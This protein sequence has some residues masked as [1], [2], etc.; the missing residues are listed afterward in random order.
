MLQR[1]NLDEWRDYTQL[2]EQRNQAASAKKKSKQRKRK[3]VSALRLQDRLRIPDRD[4]AGDMSFSWPIDRSNFWL[5]SGFGPRRK[6]DGSRGY[7]YGIDLAAVK[8]TPVNASADGVVIEA[9]RASGY[10]NT[11][12]V[13]H[14]SKYRTRYAHLSTIN[15]KMGQTVYKGD[16]IGRVGATGHIRAKKGRDGSHLHFEVSAYGKKVNPMYFLT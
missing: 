5:S 16:F 15:V 14:N 12:V 6:R 10:G 8:G 2:T 3:S 13:A 4:K 9:R 11:I 1:I 7:H